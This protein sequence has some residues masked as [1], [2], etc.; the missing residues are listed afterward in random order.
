MDK[1]RRSLGDHEAG[2]LARFADRRVFSLEVSRR[3]GLYP[4]LLLL[5]FLVTSVPEDAQPL[6]STSLTRAASRARQ[7]RPTPRA[8]PRALDLARLVDVDRP[9][10]GLS[11]APLM[12]EPSGLR[13]TTYIAAG[14]DSEGYARR[15]RGTSSRS[16]PRSRCERE[17]WNNVRRALFLTIVDVDL[18]HR[19]RMLRDPV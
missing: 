19:V 14:A 11:C 18:M 7:A 2:T 15:R 5:H 16:T 12:C 4:G 3:R 10:P 1:A 6:L 8:G 13:I 17:S 9:G